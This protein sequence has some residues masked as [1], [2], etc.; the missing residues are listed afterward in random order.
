MDQKEKLLEDALKVYRIP[1]EWVFASRVN[2]AGEVVIVTNGGKKIIHKGGD[3][4]KFEL[5]YTE[6]TGHKP[7][8]EKAWSIKYNKWISINN[9][10]LKGKERRS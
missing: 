6:I 5:S 7:E 9:L 3:P 4:A 8:E 2:E 10:K 1:Q